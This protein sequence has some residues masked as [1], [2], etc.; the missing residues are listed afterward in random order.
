MF[1]DIATSSDVSRTFE[2]HTTEDRG[3]NQVSS[4]EV[5]VLSLSA[6]ARSQ[7]SGTKENEYKVP[8][9]RQVVSV[10]AGPFISLSF[11]PR[12]RVTVMAN[13]RTDA[14]V[15][16]GAFSGAR[17][18]AGARYRASDYEIVPVNDSLYPALYNS[19]TFALG[20]YWER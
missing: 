11:Q 5:I 2:I 20:L 4:D 1:P 17:V 18:R 13:T 15:P 9:P 7:E 8:R 10:R 16:R 19:N 3:K 12:P 6:F 14:W